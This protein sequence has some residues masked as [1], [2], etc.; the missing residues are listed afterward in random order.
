MV[1]HNE[2]CQRREHSGI[3]KGP[4]LMTLVRAASVKRPGSCKIG[5]IKMIG[6]EQRVN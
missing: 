4:S 3:G 5:L 6:E 1:D 2:N